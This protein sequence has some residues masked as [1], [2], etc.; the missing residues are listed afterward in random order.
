[1]IWQIAGGILIAIIPVLVVAAGI[2]VLNHEQVAPKTG[3][4]VIGIGVALAAGII[5]LG[6]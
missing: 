6:F 2:F 5:W 1:M 3:W 4:A